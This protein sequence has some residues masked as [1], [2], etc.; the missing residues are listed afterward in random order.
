MFSVKHACEAVGMHAEIT[1]DAS[2]ILSADVVILPGVGAFGDA[3]ASLKQLNLVEP[4]R[5]AAHSGKP[6]IGICL[7]MQ[8]LMT[9]SSEFGR[10]AGLGIMPGHVT[11]FEPSQSNGQRIKV[12]HVGWNQITLPSFSTNDGW[13]HSPLE[14]IESGACVYFVHSYYVIPQDLNCIWAQTRYGSYQFCSA[15]RRGNVYA[16]Q[17]HPERSG[18]TGLMI[19][20]NIAALVRPRG[21]S[22]QLSIGGTV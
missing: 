8:L 6:L 9:E 3:M 15:V 21:S 22:H 4:L 14:G 13:A 10:H 7:G 2:K 19:Y 12:P 5:E 20:Q 18:T 17:F 11:R 1:A 16:F